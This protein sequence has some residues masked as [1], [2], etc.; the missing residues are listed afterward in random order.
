[1]DTRSRSQEDFTLIAQDLKARYSNLDAV[2]AEF[3]DTE[4]LLDYNGG[5]LIF[6]TYEGVDY[7]GYLRSAQRRGLLRQGGG[8]VETW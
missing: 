5:A 3:M 7:M 1:M 6:N 8:G 4:D 2:S